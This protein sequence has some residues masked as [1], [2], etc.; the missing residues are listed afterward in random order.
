[1]TSIANTA[2]WVN[3]RAVGERF[4]RAARS[5]DAHAGLQL[6]CARTLL[7]MAPATLADPRALELGCATAPLAR[8]QQARWPRSHWLALDLSPAMLSEARARGR[9]GARFQP[10]CAD[11]ERL[12]LAGASR[13]LVFSSFALQWCRPR[14]VMAEVAR[15]LVPGGHLM[16]A[17]PLAGSLHELTE[18]WAAADRRAHVNRLPTEQHWRAALADAGLMPSQWQCLSFT[19]HYPDVKTLVR[20]FKATGVD[21][22]QGGAAGL[23][24]K[25]AWR[26]M[27]HA[28]EQRRQ[29]AGLPLTWRVLFVRAEKGA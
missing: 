12:P 18:S 4:G 14:T 16:L 27:A 19:E 23:T 13:A 17:V 20:A 26:A 22:V 28:Y 6:A 8:A 15:V 29:P 5:Y 1:M 2:S 9:T 25:S 10:L 21:H 3:K 24:G 7:E 11:A